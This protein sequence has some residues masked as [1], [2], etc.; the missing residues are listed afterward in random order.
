MKAQNG[1]TMIELMI[2]VVVIGILAA[3]ALPSYQ[4]YMVK[5]NRAVTQ[6]FMADI[7]NREKQYLLDARAYASTLSTLGLTVP[8]SVSKHYSGCCTITVVATPPSFT[9]TATPTSSQQSSDGALTLASDGT[10]TPA[11]KW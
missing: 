5:S 6:A 1:F 7:A 3:V 10:K 8:T 9:I 2:V 11:S 4:S